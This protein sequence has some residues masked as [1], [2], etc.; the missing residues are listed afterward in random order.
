MNCGSKKQQLIGVR[1][2]IFGVAELKYERGGSV[3]RG[4]D[5]AM[6]RL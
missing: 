6:D 1:N 4:F 2:M 5:G 3:E